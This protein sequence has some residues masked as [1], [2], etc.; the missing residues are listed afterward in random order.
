MKEEFKIEKEEL[1]KDLKRI[2][3]DPTL[4]NAKRIIEEK[5]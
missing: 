3:L 1:P 5:D 2:I 4:K